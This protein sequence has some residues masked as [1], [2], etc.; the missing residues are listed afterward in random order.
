[1]VDQGLSSKC[2]KPSL[3]IAGIGSSQV[4]PPSADWFTEIAHEEIA[5]RVR[6]VEDLRKVEG[7]GIGTGHARI[8]PR[9]LPSAVPGFIGPISVNEAPPLVEQEGR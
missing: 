3:A 4:L 5:A 6:E 8:S 9:K 2:V 7:V 1:M